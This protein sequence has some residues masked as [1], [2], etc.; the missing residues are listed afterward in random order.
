MYA[1]ESKEEMDTD[2]QRQR[3]IERWRDEGH[4]RQKAGISHTDKWL[5]TEAQI[6]TENR[7]ASWD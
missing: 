7:L 6:Y 2:R 3:D 4:R 1:G 5:R